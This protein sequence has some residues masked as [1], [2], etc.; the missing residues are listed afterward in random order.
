[1]TSTRQT[2]GGVQLTFNREEVFLLEDAMLQALGHGLE[3]LRSGPTPDNLTVD[4]V[5]SSGLE[6][7]S[8][9]RALRE[10]MFDD[11]AEQS[12]VPAGSLI[13]MG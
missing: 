7:L 5:C 12:N 2:G 4:G 1:M 9:L 10:P 13:G 11:L 8:L 6:L 3:S